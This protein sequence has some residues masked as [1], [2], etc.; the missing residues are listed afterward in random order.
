MN[1]VLI[2][3]GP[4]L[5]LLGERQ[6]DIYPAPSLE[7]LNKELAGLAAELDLEPEFIQCNGE[8]EMVEALQN[9]RKRVSFVVLNPGAFTH[10]SY[11]IRDAI[12]AISVPVIEVHISNIFAREDFRSKSVVAPVCKGTI[13]GLGKE[14]YRL[15][16]IA[17][18]DLFAS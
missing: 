1:K 17:G 2:L 7:D 3:N 18:K 12:E 6:P 5:N 13:A 16:L 8:K 15:A 9:C 11:A 10:Y 4:N 14:S